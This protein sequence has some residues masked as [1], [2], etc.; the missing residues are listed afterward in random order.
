[1]ATAARTNPRAPAAFETL[2]FPEAAAKPDK[3]NLGPATTR[4]AKRAAFGRAMTASMVMKMVNVNRRTAS[5]PDCP[6]DLNKYDNESDNHVPEI[7][8]M[9]LAAMVSRA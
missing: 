3:K 5:A 4:T 8:A 7:E 1:M 6:G 9:S 2:A